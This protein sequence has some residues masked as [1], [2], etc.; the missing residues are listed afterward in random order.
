MKNWASADY[1]AIFHS[2]FPV[3][4]T[5]NGENVVTQAVTAGSPVIYVSSIPT[6]INTGATSVGMR[7]KELEDEVA[8][9]KK[10]VEKLVAQCDEYQEEIHSLTVE[11]SEHKDAL[12][13]LVGN[14]GFSRQELYL[15]AQMRRMQE[16]GWTLAFLAPS[17]IDLL[18]DRSISDFTEDGMLFYYDAA[19]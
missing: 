16:K 2:G 10:T 12:D 7:E 5:N 19:E 13:T 18:E 14:R 15:I 1:Y 9:L 17:V 11:C 6:A 3:P 4:N 8:Q